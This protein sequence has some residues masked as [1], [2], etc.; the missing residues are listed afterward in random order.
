M[1]LYDYSVGRGGNLLLNIG[2]DRRGLLPERDAE[3]F[4]EFG[5]AVKK[6]FATP[7]DITIEKEGDEYIISSEK[8]V[9]INTVVIKENLTNG[10]SVK[11][12]SIEYNFY[13]D[14]SLYSGKTIGNKRIVRIP[15]IEFG[16]DK[17]LK[18]KI[19]DFDGDYTIDDIKVYPA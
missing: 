9:D 5:N 18:L 19:T 10:E 7:I 1:G 12:F 13:V 14:M 2:P 8:T 6:Q 3:R 4:I 17:K 16:G 11:G 15:T